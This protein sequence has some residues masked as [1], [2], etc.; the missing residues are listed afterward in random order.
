M[1]KEIDV[2][3]LDDKKNHP[4]RRCPVGKH[5]V[6]EHIVHVHPSKAHPDGKV[7]VWHEHCANNPSGKEELS[8][9]EIN[10]ID[11]KYFSSLTGLPTS[12]VLNKIFPNADK[13][14]SEIRGWVK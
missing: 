2:I 1:E 12:G 14:D 5:L 3:M 4:W 10:Y 9:A 6:R 7:S 8:Y 11:E 13:Y